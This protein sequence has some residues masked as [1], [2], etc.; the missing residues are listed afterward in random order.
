MWGKSWYAA[1]TGEAMQADIRADIGS[2]ARSSTGA[3]GAHNSAAGAKAPRRLNGA[4]H[5]TYG[6]SDDCSRRWG[7][8]AAGRHTRRRRPNS[9]H[10]RGR[11]GRAQG[12]GGRQGA[13]GGRRESASRAR[14][15][16]APGGGTPVPTCLLQA[17]FGPAVSGM[18][19]L[20][21]ASAARPLHINP[22]LAPTLV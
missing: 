12:R 16:R 13:C 11:G 22:T 17:S 9:Q 21:C 10:Q 20:G 6:F 8:W 4:M 14:G 3:V 2:T 7:G 1:G 5:L 15:D 19:T 18:C